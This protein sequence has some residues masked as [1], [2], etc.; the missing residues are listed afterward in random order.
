[1]TPFPLGRTFTFEGRTYCVTASRF[2]PGHGWSVQATCISD[3][4]DNGY[5]YSFLFPA[6][7]VLPATNARANFTGGTQG[8]GEHHV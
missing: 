5:T 6:A 2:I 4:W 7:E 8:E 1:M 3:S